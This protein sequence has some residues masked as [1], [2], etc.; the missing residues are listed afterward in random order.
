[1]QKDDLSTSPVDTETTFGLVDDES[2]EILLDGAANL[3]CEIVNKFPQVNVD[4]RL[5]YYLSG[6]LATML[7][8]KTANMTILD[9]SQIPGVA[10]AEEKDCADLSKSPLK[11][12]ARQI[13]D[14]DF[15]PLNEWRIGEQRLKKGMASVITSELPESALMVLKDSNRAGVMSDP[16][17]TYTPHRVARLRIYDQDIFIAEPRVMLAYK[18]VHLCQTFDQADKSD[19][20][21]GDFESI[22]MGLSDLYS[23]DVLVSTTHEALM[24]YEPYSPNNTFLPYYN[25]AAS[26][27]MHTFF[28]AVLKQDPDIGYVEQLGDLQERW[29]GILKIIHKFDSPEAKDKIISFIQRNQG[30]IDKW[31]INASSPINLDLVA[32]AIMGNGEL[33]KNFCQITLSEP[34]SHEDVVQLLETNSW[35]MYDYGSFVSDQSKIILRPERSEI[36]DVLI[37]LDEAHLDIEIEYIE[38]LTKL[39]IDLSHLQ[40]IL[41]KSKNLS[42]EQ[43]E[44]FFKQLISAGQQSGSEG[45]LQLTKNMIESLYRLK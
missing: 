23:L 28:Q 1:M 40:L 29:I 15:V 35:A 2:Y 38:K 42:T 27:M 5:N 6:S 22:F 14:I 9:E 10:Y 18:V 30:E 45:L 26:D 4:G 16:L 44:E 12:F 17:E 13:G 43:R 25:P 31:M 41:E 8:L 20:F 7:L 36:L 33:M 3:A 24:M 34:T 32:E 19:K 39:G 11:R 37:F 21:V